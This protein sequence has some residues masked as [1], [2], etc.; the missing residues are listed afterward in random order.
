[1]PPYTLQITEE[2]FLFWLPYVEYDF[3][4]GNLVKLNLTLLE[5]W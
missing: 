4:I 5:M 1:M 2:T 3:M